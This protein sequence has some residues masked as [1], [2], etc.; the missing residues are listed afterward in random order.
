MIVLK[1]VRG[2]EWSEIYR[3]IEQPGGFSALVQLGREDL[4]VIGGY[5][6]AKNEHV[7]KFTLLKG[8]DMV[9]EGDICDKKGQ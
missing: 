6:R 1:C 3:R 5:D 9:K 2:G 7:S 8:T 4:L